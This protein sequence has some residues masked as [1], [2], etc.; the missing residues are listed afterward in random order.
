MALGIPTVSTEF[1]V[2]GVPRSFLRGVTTVTDNDSNAFA[3]AVLEL[4]AERELRERLGRCAAEDA[5][6]WNEEQKAT[7]AA[8]LKEANDVVSQA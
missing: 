5:A 4:L 3:D 2:K 1:G 6:R 7:L 8:L